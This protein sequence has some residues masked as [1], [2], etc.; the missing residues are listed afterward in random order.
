MSSLPQHRP[1]LFAV[2]LAVAALAAPWLLPNF[3]LFQLTLVLVYA[4]AILGLNL[5]TGFNGQVSLGHSAF[6]ALGAYAAAILIDQ[7]HWPYGATLPVAALVC[8]I[9]GFLFGL[10]A[11]RL[12]GSYLALATFALAVA[13]PQI[14]KFSPLESLTGGV[15]GISL[16]KPGAPLG[17]RLDADQWLYAFTLG[18]ALLAFALASR[19]VNSRSGRALMA[20][21]DHPIAARSM[22]IDVA[23]YKALTFGLSAA[24][25]G[26]AGGLSAIVV[27]YIAPDSFTVL[28]SIALLVGLVVGG[29]GSIPGAL[30]GGL[31]ILFVPNLAERVSKSLAGGIYALILLL[32]VFLMPSGIA[33]AWRRFSRSRAAR[34]L[35][36]TPQ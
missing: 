11:L 18:V 10:P 25:T 14:L 22:G 34:H 5:L 1:V 29:A 2:V 31:F 17:L 8:F 27:Q 6:F 28:F 24:F 19:L 3:V 15:A 26:V 7:M 20:I 13:M 9:V 36:S 23:M 33:G 12:E 30:I 35:T 16:D 21:R 32:V 4:I